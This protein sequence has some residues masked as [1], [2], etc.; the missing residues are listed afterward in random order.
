MENQMTYDDYIKTVESVV[1]REVKKHHKDRNFHDSVK[2]HFSMALIFSYAD[3]G[4][5][6]CDG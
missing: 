4:R 1:M 5:K 6:Y 3:I 2:L